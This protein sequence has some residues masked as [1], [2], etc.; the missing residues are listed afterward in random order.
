MYVLQYK[1]YTYTCMYMYMHVQLRVCQWLMS[2]M[3]AS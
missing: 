2:Y 1:L 3:C